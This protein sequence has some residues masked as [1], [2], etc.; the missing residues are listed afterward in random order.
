MAFLTIP[1]IRIEGIVSCVPRSRQ[2]V[3]D[4]N[5]LTSEEADKLIATTGIVERRIADS[6]ICTSD[7]CFESAKKLIDQLGWQKEEVDA[8]IFVTQTPDYVLPATSPILQDRLGLADSCFTLDISLGCSGYVY[9]FV[10]LANLMA[11]GQ[12]KKGLLLVGDTISKVCSPEDKSTFPLF[13]DAG[14]ATALIFDKTAEPIYAN[15]RSNGRGYKSIII[16]DGGY[17]SPF[18]S[19]S[20]NSTVIS[21]GIKRRSDQLILEG[22]DV[23]SFGITKAPEVIRQLLANF[24]IFE[25]DIDYFVFHQAN[26]MMNEKIRKKLGIPPEKVPY[27]LGKYGN[28]SCAT[29]PHT[30]ATELQKNMTEKS[31]K[32]VLC[33]FGVGLSWGAVYIKT[34]PLKYLGSIEL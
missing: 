14:T 3:R 19:N 30:M 10:T 20:L 27:S 5:C 22:M 25:N 34:D 13:G 1:N 18:S 23:F 32:I 16:N 29:I 15:M 31:S 28:T 6:S 9:G 7:L 33:G 24:E 8:L 12:I 21:P 4:C 2:L 11:N 26:L 17:R